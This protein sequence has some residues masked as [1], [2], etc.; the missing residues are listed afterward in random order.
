MLGRKE[1][2]SLDKQKQA[3]LLESGMNR[4]AL[5]VEV[6]NLRSAASW[7]GDVT[8]ASRGL[9][10]LLLILAPIGGFFLA[11]RS[12]RSNSRLGRWMALAKWV[13]PIYRVWKNISARRSEQEAGKPAI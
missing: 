10:P 6:E 12:R 7:V 3:L 9:A 8:A 1:L 5:Q 11:K 4:V 13:L 2:A